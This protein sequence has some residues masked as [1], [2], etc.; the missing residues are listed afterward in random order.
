MAISLSHDFLLLGGAGG[1]GELLSPANRKRDSGLRFPFRCSAKWNFFN[2]AS[3]A[4]APRHAQVQ[5][6]HGSTRLLR[7]A[8]RIK[9][10]KLA[11]FIFFIM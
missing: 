2:F 7:M 6:C 11:K 10:L 1:R 5:P 3:H 8:K 4:K 9:S